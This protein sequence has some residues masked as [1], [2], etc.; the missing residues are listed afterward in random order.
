MRVS[1][2][3]PVRTG[4]VS[5]GALWP[6]TLSTQY[7][8]VVREGS[9][10]LMAVVIFTRPNSSPLAPAVFSGEVLQ[11]T[12][13]P[14]SGGFPELRLGKLLAMSLSKFSREEPDH[15]PLRS[16]K[17]TE[18]GQLALFLFHI[19]KIIPKIIIQHNVVTLFFGNTALEWR[20]KDLKNKSK[21]PTENHVGGVSVRIA[22][23]GKVK[24]CGDNY[25]ATQRIKSTLPW[26][27]MVSISF[28]K[29]HSYNYSLPL[30]V[31]AQ[32]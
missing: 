31:A 29:T 27:G 4:E 30:D 15:K 8:D 5:S 11:A 26:K 28:N 21:Q 2:V 25:F 7:T 19:C 32:C 17:Q 10:A 22:V 1:N 14:G 9:W 16:R 12:L 3:F 24:V 20:K 23:F 6:S 13:P 18:L